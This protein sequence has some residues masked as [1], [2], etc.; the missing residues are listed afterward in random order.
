MS[1]AKN[2]DTVKIHYTTRLD[3][4]SVFQTTKEDEGPLEFT[5]GEGQVIPAFEEAV[6]GMTPG[7]AKH[8]TVKAEN[9][10]GP[11]REDLKL[12]VE[13]KMFPTEPEIGD[14]Y[15]VQQENGAFFTA[16]VVGISGLNVIMDANHPL[17]GK[18]VIFDIEL[19]EI[20]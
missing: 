12:V 6:I 15:G 17:A 14:E 1:G 16:R 13:R 19:V 20:H 8:A 11:Y 3:D 2:G 10:F 18:D 4:G 9:A 7:D 5:L